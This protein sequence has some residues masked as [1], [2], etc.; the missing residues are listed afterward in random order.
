MTR[1][2]VSCFWRDS[3]KGLLL[4]GSQ[5]VSTLPPAGKPE[6]GTIPAP[7]FPLESITH[8]S[9]S[10]LDRTASLRHHRSELNGTVVSAMFPRRGLKQ[11]RSAP[12]SYAEGVDGE[13]KTPVSSYRIFLL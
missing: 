11:V 13:L 10:A 5:K 12:K 4:Q 6:L 9:L 8:P 2:H 1:W 3:G 7:P